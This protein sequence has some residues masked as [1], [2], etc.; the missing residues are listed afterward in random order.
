MANTLKGGY[1]QIDLTSTTL[2]T[3]IYNALKTNKMVI[4]YLGDNTPFVADSI[5][6]NDDLTPSYTI[7]HGNTTY[8]VDDDNVLTTT[9]NTP[10]LYQY[11]IKG[12]NENEDNLEFVVTTTE[13]ISSK[14]DIVEIFS[15]SLQYTQGC[16]DG[17]WQSPYVAYLK[18]NL[19]QMPVNATDTY[20]ENGDTFTISSIT[21]LKQLF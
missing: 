16:V 2:Y 17:E 5:V 10:H 4:C 7:T 8:N 11:L 6:Y 18:S 12:T 20:E 19:V 9:D 14:T 3:D 1:A 15:K 13:D 21:L